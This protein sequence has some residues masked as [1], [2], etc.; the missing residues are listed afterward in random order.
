MATRQSFSTLVWLLCLAL[1]LAACGRDEPSP[2][3]PHPEFGTFRWPSFPVEL[4]PEPSLAHGARRRDLRAALAFWERH[5]GK[6]LFRLG[7]EWPGPALPYS[8]A[9]DNP[10]SIAANA[11]LFENTWTFESNI[12]GLT[13]LRVTGS[14]ITGAYILL[15]PGIPFC[16]GL[17]RG[18]PGATSLRRLLAH[19]LGHFLGLGHVNDPQ[20][21]MYPAIEPGGTLRDRTVDELALRW[22]TE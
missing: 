11:V 17:C 14:T 10:D 6:K 18:D 5:A 4:R 19:E 22:L 15:D 12:A 8:G 20:N 13:S 3:P 16:S 1:A 9:A 7:D 21:I 2:P